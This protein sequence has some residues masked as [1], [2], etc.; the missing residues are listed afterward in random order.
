MTGIGLEAPNRL[1][2]RG[3]VRGGGGGGMYVG[4]GGG[5]LRYSMA[6]HCQT[7]PVDL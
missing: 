5:A 4:G 3:D 1:V 7:S 6:T 2:D